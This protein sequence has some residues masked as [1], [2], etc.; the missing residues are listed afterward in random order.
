[1]SLLRHRN[2]LCYLKKLHRHV[3]CIFIYFTYV[4][5]SKTSSNTVVVLQLLMLKLTAVCCCFRQKVCCGI[6]YKGRY[7]EVII[8]PHLY[9]P[10]CQRKPKLH[11]PQE[12]G[13]DLEEEEEGD[14]EEEEA[15]EEQVSGKNASNMSPGPIQ[16]QE[17]EVGDEDGGGSS[18]GSV[19]SPVMDKEIVQH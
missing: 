17:E 12:E 19:Y 9:K 13:G 6:V 10:C 15:E 16:K 18:T 8:D 11:Q 14:E 3:L 4:I 1:M 7:G 5:D 2:L